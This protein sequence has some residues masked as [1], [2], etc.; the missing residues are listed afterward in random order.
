LKVQTFL[1]FN[2]FSVFS[3]GENVYPSKKQKETKTKTKP[4]SISGKYNLITQIKY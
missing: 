1:I 3:E 2:Y 4:G